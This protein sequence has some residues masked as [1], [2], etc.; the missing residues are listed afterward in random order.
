MWR[1]GCLMRGE[2]WWLR[3]QLV[4]GGQQRL[5]AQRLL[6]RGRVLGDLM[7]PEQDLPVRLVRRL[8]IAV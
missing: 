5:W 2:Q 7:G 1:G 6:W 8:T 4:L 3:R